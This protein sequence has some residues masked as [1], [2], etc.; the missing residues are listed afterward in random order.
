MN[1]FRYQ[2]ARFASLCEYTVRG[3]YGTKVWMGGMRFH[4]KSGK[5][6]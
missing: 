6:L 2:T 5:I 3:N 1:W 4:G